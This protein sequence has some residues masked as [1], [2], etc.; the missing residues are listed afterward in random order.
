M[1]T[2]DD[3]S[4]E[5]NASISGE[6][7]VGGMAAVGLVTVGADGG[8]ILGP[9]PPSATGPPPLQQGRLRASAMASWDGKTYVPPPFPAP[10]LDERSPEEVM[11]ANADMSRLAVG[12]TALFLK[13]QMGEKR[14]ARSSISFVTCMPFIPVVKEWKKGEVGEKRDD[15]PAGVLVSGDHMA[16]ERMEVKEGDGK[17]ADGDSK[18]KEFVI[19]EGTEDGGGWEGTAVKSRGGG[20]GIFFICTGME[21]A[22]GGSGLDSVGLS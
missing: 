10:P 8:S 20:F 22:W 6:V 21:R 12:E 11:E 9:V 19:A 3:F 1:F 2:S 17:T 13:L 7:G 14:L 4:G 18:A 5:D 16:G 15:V